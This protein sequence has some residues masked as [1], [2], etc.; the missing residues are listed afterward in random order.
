MSQALPLPFGDVR[1]QMPI[2]D[3]LDRCFTPQKLAQA[4]V[5]SVARFVPAPKL[6]IE[7]SVGGGAFVRAIR[8]R[9]PDVEVWGCDLDPYAEGFRW[10][11]E[12]V[13]QDWVVGAKVLANRARAQ[14]KRVDLV[15]GNPSFKHAISHVAAGRECF[16]KAVQSFILPLAYLGVGEWQPTWERYGLAELQ[17]IA[18][19]PW[20]E[21]MRETATYTWEPLKPGYRGMRLRLPA[22]EWR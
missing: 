21:R 15:V 17:P 9:W 20:P 22:L 16:P 13:M 14:G 8:A 19:R 2:G 10:C 11:D 12:V 4:V 18:G 6:I 7:P 3:E 1:P 5:E